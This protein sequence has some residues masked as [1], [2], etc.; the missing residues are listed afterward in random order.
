M[1]GMG[2]APSTRLVYG[3]TGREPAMPSVSLGTSEGGLTEKRDD[4]LIHGI[5]EG[6]FANVRRTNQN[7]ECL[8]PLLL[9]IDCRVFFK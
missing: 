5:M 3:E 6:L 8:L 7:M 4:G 2:G 1:K 9:G